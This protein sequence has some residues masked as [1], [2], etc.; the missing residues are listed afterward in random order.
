MTGLL[1]DY[2]TEKQ[3]AGELNMSDRTLKRYRAMPDGLPYVQLG[4]RILY[5]V[6]TVLAWIQTRTVHPNPRRGAS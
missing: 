5:H 3:L 2:R 4:G 1:Q 6:P